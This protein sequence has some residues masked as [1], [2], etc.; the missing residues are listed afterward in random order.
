MPEK[1]K[2]EKKRNDRPKINKYGFIHLSA[3]IYEKLGLPKKVDIP[4]KI[5]VEPPD[6]MIVTIEK[7]RE[8]ATSSA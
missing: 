8:K 3:T 6:R 5:K 7:P 2:P 4:I 1:T